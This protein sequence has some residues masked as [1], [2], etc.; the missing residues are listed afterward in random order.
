M[1]DTMTSPFEGLTRKRLPGMHMIAALN[2]EAPLANSLAAF[3]FMMLHDKYPHTCLI[4]QARARAAADT[5]TAIRSARDPEGMFLGSIFGSMANNG[6]C[7]EEWSYLSHEEAFTIIFMADAAVEQTQR[8]ICQG[9][10]KPF[11]I[12]MGP[13]VVRPDWAIAHYDSSGP[14]YRD[15]SRVHVEKLRREIV[16]S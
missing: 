4:E 13:M 1:N 3:F 15:E 7:L 9:V 5:D 6:L 10:E 12:P 8:W 2:G 14:S 16:E 11:T